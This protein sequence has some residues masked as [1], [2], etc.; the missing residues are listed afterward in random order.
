MNGAVELRGQSY[1]VY[2]YKKNCKQTSVKSILNSIAQ[3]HYHSSTACHGVLQQCL[4]K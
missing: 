3:P 2:N 4:A 1:L